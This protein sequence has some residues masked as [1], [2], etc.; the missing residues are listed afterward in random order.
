VTD[1][2]GGAAERRIELEEGSWL[3]RQLNK[4]VLKIYYQ[5]QYLIYEEVSAMLRSFFI[6]LS[7]AAWARKIVTRWSIAWKMASRWMKTWPHGVSMR[8]IL[9][10]FQPLRYPE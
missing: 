3:Y 7:K 2:G 8:L 10:L 1:E 6:Y 9:C 5:H 4:F